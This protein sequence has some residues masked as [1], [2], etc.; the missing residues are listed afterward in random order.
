MDRWKISH[1]MYDC[2]YLLRPSTKY[3]LL[4]EHINFIHV[5]NVMK[6]IESVWGI[7]RI[8]VPP[9]FVPSGCC[10]N[11]DDSI[12]EEV[13]TKKCLKRGGTTPNVVV[14]R[15]PFFTLYSI[16]S[17]V[18]GKEFRMDFPLALSAWFTKVAYFPTGH[19]PSCYE[20]PEN[21]CMRGKS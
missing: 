5:A 9:T 8:D 12:G 13:C 19:F 17:V 3:F 18:Y 6:R 2:N 10:H 21:R 16:F 14:V 20:T 4:N 11:I 7:V 1:L 15:V